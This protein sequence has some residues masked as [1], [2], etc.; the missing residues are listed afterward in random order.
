[1]LAVDGGH[2]AHAQQLH[3]APLLGSP[4][5]RVGVVGRRGGGRRRQLLVR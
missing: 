2:G 5:R 1:M 4:A 3:V